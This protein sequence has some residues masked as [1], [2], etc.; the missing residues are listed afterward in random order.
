ME[1]KAGKK[2]RLILDTAK[3]IILD[4]DFSSLT[5]DAV[6]KKANISKGG[7]LYHFPNKESL[8]K[9]L[10]QYIF[11]EFTFLFY[12]YAENDMNETGK[13]T[14]ALIET[15]KFDLEH[16]GELNV[17]ILAISF[18]EPEIAKDISE[19]YMTIL[20]KLE[21]DKINPLTA[22]I[23]RHTLDGIYYSQ[24]LNVAPL[25]KEKTDEVFQ[26]LLKMTKSEEKK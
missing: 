13:W 11:D 7:L 8:I 15:T 12:K 14:R 9:G 25:K 6:A 17:G 1:S 18:L 2:R 24:L 16:N 19:S 23:I 4:S 26:H 22:T 20:K 3:Q 5:L 21:D 10:A